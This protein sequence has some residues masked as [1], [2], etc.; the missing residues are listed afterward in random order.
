MFIHV[1]D[2][3]LISYSTSLIT[4]YISQ[5]N[6]LFALKDLGSLYFFFGFELTRNSIGLHLCQTKYA[7]N[8]LVKANM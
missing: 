4:K 7:K 6:N 3:L 2:I 8:I 5:L 1:D